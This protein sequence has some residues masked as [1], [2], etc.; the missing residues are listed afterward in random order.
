MSDISEQEPSNTIGE[1]S[2]ALSSEVGKAERVS[3]HCSKIDTT[4]TP[5]EKEERSVNKSSS[6]EINGEDDLKTTILNLSKQIQELKQERLST[7]FQHRR[8]YSN[9]DP[10]RLENDLPKCY[11]S[12]SQSTKRL[13]S[14]AY[15]KKIKTYSNIRFL[16]Y[17]SQISSYESSS[18]EEYG[19]VHDKKVHF[20]TTDSRKGKYNSHQSHKKHKPVKGTTSPVGENISPVTE[21]RKSPMRELSLSPVREDHSPVRVTSKAGKKQQ[22]E[23]NDQEKWKNI[24]PSAEIFNQYVSLTDGYDSEFERESQSVQSLNFDNVKKIDNH[25]RWAPL[26]MKKQ[27]TLSAVISLLESPKPLQRK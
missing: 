20:L 22:G 7:S 18:D 12:H 10:L 14:Q 13:R 5:A 2:K 25:W 17:H 27:L 11:H 3:K 21:Q 8:F 6:R 16:S 26:C 9:P 24:R 19:H 23:S 4:T 15:T 1:L